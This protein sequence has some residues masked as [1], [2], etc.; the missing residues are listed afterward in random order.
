[1]LP[2]PQAEEIKKQLITQ[3]DSLKTE[4]KDQIKQHIQSLN[5]QQLEEFLKQNKIQIQGAGQ[6]PQTGQQGC[7]FC[8]ITK[9]QIPSY[10]IIEN[11]NGIG[12]LEVNPLTKGHTIILPLKHTPIEKLSTSI[13][14]LAKKTAK[15]LKTKL[16]PEDVK[17][18]TSSFQG[19]SMVNVIPL[20]KEPPK[21]TKASESELKQ[22]Q[23]KLEVKKRGP[24][25]IKSTTMI[26]TKKLQEISFRIP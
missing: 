12:V 23:S 1:M 11:K 20:Y 18:E 6:Q 21:K 15:R 19:H 2:K 10:K 8:S 9:G 16:K 13:L 22:L 26:P 3:V 14:G 24:R 4:N 5:E 25:A 17:I 7:I